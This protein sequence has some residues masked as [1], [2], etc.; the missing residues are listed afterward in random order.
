MPVESLVEFVPP[1]PTLTGAD[2]VP[3]P[4]GSEAIASFAIVAAPTSAASNERVE[5]FPPPSCAAPVESVAELPPAPN[6][7]VWPT[8]TEDPAAL[9]PADGLV[10]SPPNCSA[11]VDPL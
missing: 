9:P 4:N 1:L 7:A 3:P 11:P 5:L 6:P 10:C 8:P 2:A